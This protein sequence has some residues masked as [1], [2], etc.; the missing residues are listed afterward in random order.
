MIIQMKFLKS[1]VTVAADKWHN[2]ITGSVYI[3]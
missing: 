1:I 3:T 2:L